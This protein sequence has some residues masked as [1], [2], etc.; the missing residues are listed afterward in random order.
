MD[1][2]REEVKRLLTGRLFWILFAG[3]LA[4]NFW[5]IASYGE[6]MPL[7]AA[8]AA[9]K[10]SGVHH[11]TTENTEE[12]I[13]AFAGKEPENRQISVR[14]AVEAVPLITEQ[15]GA[16][17]FAEIF[18]EDLQLTGEAAD[19]VRNAC[20]PLEKLLLRDRES[21][22]AEALFVP[23]TAGFFDLFSYFLPTACT[24]ETVL[25]AVLLMLRCVNAPYDNRSKELVYTTKTGRRLNRMQTESALFTILL[26]AVALWGITILFAEGVFRMGELWQVKAGSMMMLHF[27]YPII[28]RFSIS[29]STYMLLQAALSVCMALLFGIAAAFFVTRMHRT[30]TAFFKIS[31]YCAL[32]A[33]AAEIA[34]RDSLLFFILR[35]Q[36][37]EFIKKAGRWFAS[38]AG[39]LSVRY[40][41][42]A[43]VLFWGALLLLLLIRQ[44]KKFRLEDI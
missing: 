4:V 44:Y 17:D 43:F 24:V 28:C 19:M 32:A 14:R 36:P 13:A 30:V 34:P 42:A 39:F 38:G 12:I 8:A 18:I 2:R 35:F 9:L 29:L 6:N 40:Y 26:F 15:L 41:E 11:V 33:A 25:A 3:A 31:F 23:C 27:F 16:A 21:G 20:A 10:E 7:V 5:L 37:V 1:C 22:T